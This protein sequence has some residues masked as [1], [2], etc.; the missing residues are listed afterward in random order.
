MNKVHSMWSFIVFF[1]FCKFILKIENDIISFLISLLGSI[2][3][4]TNVYPDIF[5]MNSLEHFT[6]KEKGKGET[7]DI[8]EEVEGE[9]NTAIDEE[10]ENNT[11]IDEEA[12]NNTAIDEEA[13]PD[14]DADAEDVETFSTQPDEKK[15][16]KTDKKNMLGFSLKKSKLNTK[17][18]LENAFKN[19][20][21]TGLKSM[22]KDTKDLINTQ[23]ELLKT[24]QDLA[25]VLTEGKQM[26]ESF[27][28]YFGD[29]GK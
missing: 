21:K 3:V 25:P 4:G 6:S 2:Y 14:A 20:S 1:S 10:A 19:L 23:K 8:D 26:L 5:Q 13:E 24:V 11:A 7:T 22:S 28:G 17:A 27:K 12:E 9:D 16:K 15:S 18:T 29:S